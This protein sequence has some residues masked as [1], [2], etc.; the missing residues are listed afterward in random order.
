MSNAGKI[1]KNGL[2]ELVLQAPQLC[3][4]NLQG[5]SQVD[6]LFAKTL[7]H[8]P[9]L[10]ELNLHH[11]EN[12]TDETVEQ[13]IQS[14]PNLK[15]LDLEEG[16]KCTGE[17]WIRT[18]QNTKSTLPLLENLRLGWSLI[19]DR[20]ICAITEIAKLLSSRLATLCKV[21]FYTHNFFKISLSSVFLILFKIIYK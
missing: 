17:G 20:G 13:I 21:F 18:L 1:T 9:H 2:C 3:S 12:V 11:C 7:S 6:T 16:E 14:C 5:C 8:C 19:N 4:I 10:A 15:S